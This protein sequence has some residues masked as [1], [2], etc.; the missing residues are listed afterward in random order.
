MANAGLFKCCLPDLCR[1]KNSNVVVAEAVDFDT[2]SGTSDED[3]T[4][5]EEQDEDKPNANPKP[6]QD[7]RT[8]FFERTQ[9]GADETIVNHRQVVLRFRPMLPLKKGANVASW[10]DDKASSPILGRITKI[11]RHLSLQK[12]KI[13][14]TTMDLLKEDR[15]A[16]FAFA[17]P[18]P[19][20]YLRDNTTKQWHQ[21]IYTTATDVHM[22]PVFHKEDPQ[23]QPKKKTKKNAKTSTTTTTAAAAEAPKKTAAAAVKKKKVVNKEESQQTEQDKEAT[24]PK[25]NKKKKKKKNETPT[26]AAAAAAVLQTAAAAAAVLQTAAK[27]VITAPLQKTPGNAVPTAVVTKDDTPV[28]PSEITPSMLISNPKKNLDIFCDYWDDHRPDLSANKPYDEGRIKAMQF[29]RNAKDDSVG[30]TTLVSHICP[31]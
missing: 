4:S 8:P 27:N 22:R 1:A 12:R 11:S 23:Q 25:K 16:R 13:T 18:A 15:P 14:L 9:T 19:K 17:L 31:S 26:T 5:S 29:W 7:D 10:L 3:A 21:V 2:E 24:K 20:T 28:Q 30:H 6:Y